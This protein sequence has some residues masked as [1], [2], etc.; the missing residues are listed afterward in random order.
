MFCSRV[1]SV[2]LSAIAALLPLTYVAAQP[3]Q[4]DQIQSNTSVT[5]RWGQRP[6]VFRY[7]LQ[8]SADRDFTDILFDRL[9]SGNQTE[10]NDLPPGR[11]FWRIAPLTAKLGEFSSAGIVEVV[12]RSLSSVSPATSAPTSAIGAQLQTTNAIV[13]GGGW[14]AA[15]G[16]LNAPQLAHLRRTDSCDIVVTNSDGV[17]YALDSA[18]GV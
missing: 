13:V 2:F 7:R 15:I 14:R 17:T 1:K 5:L 11:Y 10:V 3:R 8:L 9:V 6:G 4:T 16:E 12:P 18:T